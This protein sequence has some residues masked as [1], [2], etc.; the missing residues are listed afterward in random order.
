MSKTHKPSA[1][2]RDD[3]EKARHTAGKFG[4]TRIQ[5]HVFLCCDT[6]EAGCA[7]KQ[8]VLRSW[9]FLRERLRELKLS[10]RGQVART[11]MRCV[12]VCKAGPIA[13]VYP[14]GVWY[15]LCDPPVLERIIQE[16]LI[17]GQVVEDCVNAKPDGAEAVVAADAGEIGA[18]SSS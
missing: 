1:K 3:L 13:V 8:R 5:R 14:E 2:E 9:K 6:K 16:H 17:G 10:K 4:M 15:G 18:G 11:P 12:D 7:S